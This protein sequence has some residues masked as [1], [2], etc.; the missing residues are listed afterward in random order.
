MPFFSFPFVFLG[1]SLLYLPSFCHSEAEAAAHMYD[2]DPS[3]PYTESYTPQVAPT[4]L[5]DLWVESLELGEPLSHPSSSPS[6]PSPSAAAAAA[7]AAAATEGEA[8]A[9]AEAQK[10][11]EAK[12]N[13]NLLSERRWKL[14]RAFFFLT[15]TPVLLGVLYGLALTPG[16]PAK[17][18]SFAGGIAQVAAYIFSLM[19]GLFLLFYSL[20]YFFL[21]MLEYIAMPPERPSPPIQ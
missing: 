13:K 14:I 18:L 2:D 15:F 3:L 20:A 6:P 11:E 4:T 7:A 1:C 21:K 5:F 9:A 19:F 16:Y 8:A 12:Y 10:V 17:K